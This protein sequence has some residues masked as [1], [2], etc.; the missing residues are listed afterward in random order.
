MLLKLMS[1]K[2]HAINARV[3]TTSPMMESTFPEWAREF[4]PD[5]SDTETW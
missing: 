1:M 5:R 4:F 2:M 3:E